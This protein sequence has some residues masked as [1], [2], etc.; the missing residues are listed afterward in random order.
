M[1]RWWYFT[2]G[3]TALCTVCM[4]CVDNKKKPTTVPFS[5]DG[6]EPVDRDTS[7]VKVFLRLRDRRGQNHGQRQI[8]SG[9]H[10]GHSAA[11]R[12]AQQQTQRG[13]TLE[14][15]LLKLGFI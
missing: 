1:L 4:L 3:L 10:V 11:G 15:N 8:L 9:S 12:P 5:G 6:E 7:H 14:T 2:A 13:T